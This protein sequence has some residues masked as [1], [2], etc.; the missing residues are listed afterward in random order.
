MTAVQFGKSKPTPGSSQSLREV[1]LQNAEV[2]AQKL[3][4]REIVHFKALRV[5]LQVVVGLAGV[6][7][8]FAFLNGP[9]FAVGLTRIFTPWVEIAYPTDTKLHLQEEDLVIKEGDRA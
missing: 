9:F 5:P 6:I 8:L 4:P 1:T 2:A 3:Q 7:A